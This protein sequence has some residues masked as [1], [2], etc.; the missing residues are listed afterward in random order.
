MG[1][2]SWRTFPDCQQPRNKGR[3][4]EL[5]L[6]YVLARTERLDCAWS[7]FRMRIV[8]RP[9][10]KLENRRFEGGDRS[11]FHVRILLN[12]GGI[13]CWNGSSNFRIKGSGAMTAF[14]RMQ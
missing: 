11:S 6:D 5:V 4:Q 10:F 8:I 9:V 12:L 14:G 1:R 2:D 13:C 7:V 3:R